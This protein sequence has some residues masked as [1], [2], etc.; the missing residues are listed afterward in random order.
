MKAVEKWLS[1]FDPSQEEHAHHFLEALWLCQQ[2]N[3][4]DTD[5]VDTVLNSPVAHARN[6]AKNG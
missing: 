5:L 2:H 4:I 1:K 6:A 3:V